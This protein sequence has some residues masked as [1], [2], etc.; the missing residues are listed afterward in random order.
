MGRHRPKS[1]L[2]DRKK[3]IG[4]TKIPR[5]DFLV[6]SGAVVVGIGTGVLHAANTKPQKPVVSA[7]KSSGIPPSSGYLLVDPKKCQGCMTCMLACSLV[8]EGRENI[9]LSR[10]QI[11]QNPFAGFPGDILLE[12]CRQC[13]SP[14]CVKACPTGALHADTKNGNIRMVNVKKCIG[15]MRCI[16][17]CPFEPGRAI[18]NFE[19]KHSQLCDLCSDTPFWKEPGGPSGKQACVAVCP[20]NAIKFTK[21]IPVQ[22]GDAG[23]TV[24][25]RGK[26]WK[27]LGYPT[28]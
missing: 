18:W 8:H 1:S 28:D 11:I 2:K 16:N 21:D 20:V 6:I 10:I 12:Q 3:K 4:N 5:R 19:E 24:N 14:A 7:D 17:A 22:E 25:L 26:A 15:C 23:Y 27:K 13:V 9:S